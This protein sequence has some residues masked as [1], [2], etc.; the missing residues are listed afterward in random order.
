[1]SHPPVI[2]SVDASSGAQPEREMGAAE[3]QGL[4]LSIKRL[5]VGQRVEL[6]AELDAGGH[7]E[8]VRS[9]LESR[10]TET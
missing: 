2:V 8:E 10:L 6:L 3:L 5:S 9:L 7:D 1:M 4:L